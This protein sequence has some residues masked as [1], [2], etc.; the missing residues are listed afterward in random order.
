MSELLGKVECLEYLDV[1]QEWFEM[2]IWDERDELAFKSIR[3]YV[4]DY[5]DP[6][7]AEL[8]AEVLENDT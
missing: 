4:K 2:G 8:F 1:L 5:V 7:Q 3:A 6:R